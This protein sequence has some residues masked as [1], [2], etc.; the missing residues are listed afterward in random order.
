MRYRR[1]K[2]IG[3]W[4][5]LCIF[6]LFS[7]DFTN[8]EDKSPSQSP[9]PAKKPQRALRMSKLARQHLSDENNPNNFPRTLGID[10]PGTTKR[11][12]YCSVMCFPRVVGGSY[13]P[14]AFLLL[15]SFIYCDVLGFSPP[16]CS[17]R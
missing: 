10:F 1:C 12:F 5:V 15:H 14:Q 13:L 9:K 17:A 7:T 2:L 11:V 16:C 3:L 4:L 8:G 6:M